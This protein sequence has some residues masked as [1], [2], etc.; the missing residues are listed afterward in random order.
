MRVLLSGLPLKVPPLR[1]KRVTHVGLRLRLAQGSQLEPHLRRAAIT[2]SYMLSG[3]LGAG[4]RPDR[5]RQSAFAP[6]N[7]RLRPAIWAGHLLC[8]HVID[9]LYVAFFLDKGIVLYR[10]ISGTEPWLHLVAGLMEGQKPL[11]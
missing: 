9:I 6:G 4:R 8:G 7:D 3:A 5:D 10:N 2:Y 1:R 11:S